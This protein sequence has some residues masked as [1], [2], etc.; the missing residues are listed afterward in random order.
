M[1]RSDDLPR[2]ENPAIFLAIL[3]HVE[4]LQKSNDLSA[5]VA[6][7]WGSSKG[8]QAGSGHILG[9]S[10]RTGCGRTVT[11]T[12]VPSFH[13]LNNSVARP[14]VAALAYESHS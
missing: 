9:I 5:D 1:E 10:V 14:D 11:L 12:G 2:C 7:V 13:P 6:D 4:V 3:L 8:L